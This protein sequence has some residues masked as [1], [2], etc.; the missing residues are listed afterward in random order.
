MWAAAIAF[1]VLTGDGAVA[2]TKATG[3]RPNRTLL[4]EAQEIL[5]KAIGRAKWSEEQKFE[6]K[7]VWRRHEITEQYDSK[8]KVKKR[9]DKIYGVVP[10]DGVPYSRLLQKDGRQPSEKEIR[11]EQENEKRFRERLAK[12]RSQV[13]SGKK[14]REDD[15]VRFNEELVARYQW[16]VTGQEEVNGR[17]AYVLG[18]QPRSGDLPVKRTL[19]RLLNRLAGRLWVDAEDFEIARVDLHLAE[20]ISAW[21]GL[22]ASVKKFVLRFEQ[23]KVDQTAW[24]PSYIDGYLDGRILIRTMRVK[25]W[26]RNSDFRPAAMA[27]VLPA[28]GKP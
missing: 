28:S 3:V 6:G 23:S 9:E 2:Q 25:V 11:E 10:I 8:G 16:E 18:F 20:N 19:D 15:E 27:T 26:Q 24:L 21:G 22:L 4:P 14:K 17:V 1:S 13:A 7:F 5:R 12:Q